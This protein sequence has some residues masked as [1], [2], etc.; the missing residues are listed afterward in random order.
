[1]KENNPRVSTPYGDEIFYYAQV[2]LVRE[3]AKG[4][5]WGW[6]EVRPDVI[7]G[8]A[9][10]PGIVISLC[11][12]KRYIVGFV[13]TET[14]MN[15]LE[16]VALYLALYRFV[17]GPGA[18][19]PFPGSL[20][21]F[22][23]THTDTSQ[24]I[25]TKA[26][27]YLSVV[28]PTEANNEA[29]N[30]AD[31]ATPGPWSVKWPMLAGYFELKGTCPST[32]EWGGID[33]WWNEHQEDYQKMCEMYGLQRREISESAWIFSKVSLTM[34]NHNREL[35]LDKIRSIGFT[36]ELPVGQGHYVTVDRM[37]NERILPPKSVLAGSHV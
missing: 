16:P 10:V 27:I 3:A 30:V 9:P 5:Q 37:V 24:D 26:E 25:M 4:K 34:L 29:F 31:T 15:L 2:D 18:T 20:K 22:A 8:N 36:E 12:T 14:G 7:I 11:D 35:S 21:S 19:V 1:M 13:P 6:C 28:K 32:D 33:Q 17:H 23:Y